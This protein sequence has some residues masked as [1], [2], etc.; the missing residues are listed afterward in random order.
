MSNHD[1]T[2]TASRYCR[3][4]EDSNARIAMAMLLTMRGTP[5]IYYGEEIGMRNISLSRKEIMDPVGRYYWPIIKGRDGCR[6]PMQWNDSPNAGFSTGKPWLK[7]HPNYTKRNVAAQ[8]D[9]AGSLLNFTRRLIALRKEY[10]ALRDGGIIFLEPPQKDVLAYLR[11]S[12]EGTILVALNF[13]HQARTF[14]LSPGD[15]QPLLSTS[16]R[17]VKISKIIELAPYEVCLLKSS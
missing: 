16:A 17:E 2:R 4:E 13:S 14:D 5:F 9:D 1:S 12:T 7:L 10:R 3:G 6:A 15:W 8:E 11:L